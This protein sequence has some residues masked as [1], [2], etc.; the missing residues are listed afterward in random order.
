MKESKSK[1]PNRITRKI[2]K[3]ILHLRRNKSFRSNRTAFL[4]SDSKGKDLK[5]LKEK[6][7]VRFFYRGGKDI[8][9]SDI[10]RFAKFQVL[11]K[12]NKY[13][14]LLFWFGT[15]SLTQKN[16]DGLFVIKDDLEQAIKDTISDYKELKEKLLKLNHRAKILFLECPYFSLSMFNEKRGKQF[17]N[18]YF[19][20][21]Q[22]QLLKAIDAHNYE[23]RLLNNNLKD[24]APSFNKDFTTRSHRKNRC[25]K[26][27]VDYSQ[28]RDGCHAGRKIA[29]LWL[30]RIHRLVY[31][32]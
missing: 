19:T 5:F 21:Q 10:Q 12:Q 11:R 4:L 32:I 6:K 22:G 13:P 26:N 27:I 31:R 1:K 18:N 9:D 23:I 3:E 2:N 25:P 28:L 20:Q 24:K 16:T 14:V 15:C 7:Y 8:T 30:L 29:E 17:K